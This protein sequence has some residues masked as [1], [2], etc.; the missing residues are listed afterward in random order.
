MPLLRCLCTKCNELRL[1]IRAGAATLGGVFDVIF[2]LGGV[3]S[4]KN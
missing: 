3:L 1:G 4:K 2:A